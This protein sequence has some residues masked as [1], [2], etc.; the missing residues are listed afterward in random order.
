MFQTVQQ[1]PSAGDPVARPPDATLE[2]VGIALLAYGLVQLLSRVLDKVVT[3]RDAAPPSFGPEDRKR[4]EQVAEILAAERD[5]FR[6]LSEQLE[7]QQ[8][9]V[10]VALDELRAVGKHNENV[11]RKLRALWLRVG[12]RRS[13][14]G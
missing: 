14:G 4:L 5:R 12:R 13:D 8:R 7:T 10:G 2:T 3:N 6:R 11:L 1:P 9:L